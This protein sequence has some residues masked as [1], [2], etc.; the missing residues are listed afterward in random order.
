MRASIAVLVLFAAASTALAGPPLACHPW[1]LGDGDAP[2]WTWVDHEAMPSDWLDRAVAALDAEPETLIRLHGIQRVLIAAPTRVEVDAF[3]AA[4]QLRAER[5]GPGREARRFDHEIARHTAAFAAGGE[6]EQPDPG[7]LVRIVRA[8]GD[9]AAAWLALARAVTPLMRV[10]S[11]QEHARAFV[12][13]W[14]LARAEPVR[15][16]L[17]WDLDRLEAYLLDADLQARGFVPSR[18]TRL[19]EL[20][21]LAAGERG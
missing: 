17:E 21:R 8:L 15:K 11:A 18:D 3:L 9:D 12:A 19:A 14:D 13:A 7:E 1:I 5:E 10:G 20:R 2:A 4:L 6:G 16:V